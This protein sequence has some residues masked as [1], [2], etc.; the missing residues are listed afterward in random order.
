MRTPSL[1]LAFVLANAAT[2]FAGREYHASGDGDL[3]I[4]AHGI[5]KRANSVPC[6]KPSDCTNSKVAQG[7]GKQSKTCDLKQGLCYLACSRDNHCATWA[8]WKGLKASSTCPYSD[9]TPAQRKAIGP[10]CYMCSEG[11]EYAGSCVTR[12]L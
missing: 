7:W 4:G 1:F 10:K 8:G 5:S 3:S 9:P 12:I 11:P 6:K 2:A